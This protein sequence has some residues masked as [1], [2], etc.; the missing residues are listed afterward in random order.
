MMA[1]SSGS[2]RVYGLGLLFF[3][4]QFVSP[5]V[6]NVGPRRVVPF[7][8]VRRFLYGDLD[9]GCNSR[10]RSAL[11]HQILPNLSA[12]EAVFIVL[13]FVFDPTL[14]DLLPRP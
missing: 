14:D 2:A 1:Y 7:S 10:T 4:T 8:E 12:S 11:R 6:R 5:T 13:V 9:G 3:L